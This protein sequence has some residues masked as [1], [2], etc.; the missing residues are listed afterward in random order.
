MQEYCVGIAMATDW[1]DEESRG[2]DRRLV[3]RVLGYFVPYW[4]AA[5]IAL[6]CIAVGAVLGLA[7]A[8][9][10]R[11]LIDELAGA[12]PEFGTVGPR[13]RRGDCRGRGRRVDRPGGGLSDRAHQPGH[14]LR[15][16]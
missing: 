16:A 9:V 13:G 8:L 2:I 15:P 11:D 10:F 14:H 6:A 4:R 5:L 3:R 1:G 7:P 12:Q